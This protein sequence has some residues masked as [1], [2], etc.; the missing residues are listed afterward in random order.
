MRQRLAHHHGG[1]TSVPDEL[2][3]DEPD[4][5]AS[6]DDDDITHPHSRPVHAVHST[7]DRLNEHALLGR[8]PLRNCVELR[9]GDDTIFRHASVDIDAEC[10]QTGAE[11]DKAAPAVRTAPAGDVGVHGDMRSLGDPLQVPSRIRDK[12]RILMTED[13]RGSGP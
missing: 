1:C 5:P 9:G 4:R 7:G 12:P 11:V 2:E 8:H 10:A 13:D 3:H 6:Q